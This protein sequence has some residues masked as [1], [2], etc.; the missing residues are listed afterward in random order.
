MARLP[1]DSTV[2]KERCTAELEALDRLAAVR[3]AAD[4]V[5]VGHWT[6]DPAVVEEMTKLLTASRRWAERAAA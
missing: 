6:L 5:L 3:L 4:A 1:S 2:S